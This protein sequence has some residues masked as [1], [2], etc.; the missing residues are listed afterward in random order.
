[1]VKMSNIDRLR[2]ISTPAEEDWFKIA[3]EWDKEDAYL[4]KSARIAVAVLSVLREHKMTKQELAI[5]MGVS[6]QYVSKIVKGNENLT[7][8]TISKL[9][10]ALNIKLIS[11]TDHSH[12]STTDEKYHHRGSNWDKFCSVKFSAESNESMS[13]PTTY[14]YYRYRKFSITIR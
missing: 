7:L 14:Q 13:R 6:A 9:E 11:V 8:E 4:E 12:P 5:K 1:M 3:E 10:K 2:A